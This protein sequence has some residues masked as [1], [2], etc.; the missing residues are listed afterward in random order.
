ML[1]EKITLDVAENIK[2]RCVSDLNVIHRR[3]AVH[4]EDLC[5]VHNS[6]PSLSSS[7]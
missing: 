4:R 2:K 6:T 3:A 5:I 7:S 1:K